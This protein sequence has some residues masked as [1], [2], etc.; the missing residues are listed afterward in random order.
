MNSIIVSPYIGDF[1]TEILHFW[2]HVNWLCQAF[3]NHQIF[4][5][6]HINRKF[7]Y[8][9][10][11]FFP[12]N[13]YLSRTE[14]NQQQWIHKDISSKDYKLIDEVYQEN[15]KSLFDVKKT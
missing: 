4:V 1:R 8:K 7:L 9:N 14:F 5:G 2:P 6:S 15:I 10:V 11:N 12:V 3:P 13:L